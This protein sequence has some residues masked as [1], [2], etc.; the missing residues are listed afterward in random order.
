MQNV[1]RG[2]GSW[3]GNSW[4]PRGTYQLSLQAL[5]EHGEWLELPSEVIEN[6]GHQLKA[7]GRKHFDEFH[8]GTLVRL[9][10]TDN[11]GQM[12]YSPV[13]ELDCGSNSRVLVF[14]NPAHTYFYLDA[15]N[16]ATCRLFDLRGVLVRE[17]EVDDQRTRIDT[18][19]LVPGM[20]V[21]KSM[22]QDGQINIAQVMNL[23]E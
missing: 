23:D 1:F 6:A 17:I 13:H 22:L 12:T 16:V 15:E 21:L 19:E 18:R 7:S 2:A 9:Q 11:S 4:L 5:D 20:Y 10:M 8:A 14:P 3:D